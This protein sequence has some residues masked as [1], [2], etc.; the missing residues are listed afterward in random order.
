MKAKRGLLEF[1]YF[2]PG[3]ENL[4]PRIFFNSTFLFLVVI[5]IFYIVLMLYWG[6][7]S[8]LLVWFTMP[9]FA[10]K[11]RLHQLQIRYMESG[12]VPPQ[13]SSSVGHDQ[14]RYWDS[15]EQRHRYRDNGWQ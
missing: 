3:E 5:V 8:L 2:R 13:G 11:L 1:D 9:L 6:A 12:V 4:L 14:A 7:L 10:R 15:I